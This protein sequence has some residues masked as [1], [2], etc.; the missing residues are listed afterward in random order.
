MAVFSYSALKS[1]GTMATGE[2]NAADRADAFRRLGRSGLQPVSLEAKLAGGG[3]T[4]VAAPPKKPA[5]APKPTRADQPAQKPAPAKASA[6]AKA[7]ARSPTKT[8][9]KLASGPVRLKRAHVVLFT[10]ELS[11]LLG[12][13]LQLEPALRI[14]E[15]RDELSNLKIVTGMIRQ[16]VRD[17]G[18][19]SNALRTSSPSFGELY[20][21]LAAAGEVSGALATI[22]KRQ[23]IYLVKLQELQNKVVV[24]M[25]Y[26]FCLLIAVVAVSFLFVSFL[27]P[28]L[29]S[30][31]AETGRELP[32][33]AKF[34]LAVSDFLGAYWWALILLLVAAVLIFRKVITIPPYEEKWHRV[35]LHLPLLGGVTSRR[36]FVQVV[37]T[38]SNLVGNGLPLLKGL[39]LTRNATINLYGRGL[40]D[41]VIV[42]V[43]EG[44]ALSRAMRK[45]GFFPPL[46][47][48]M[49]AVGEQTGNLPVALTRAAQRYDKELEKQIQRVTAMMQPVILIILAA[50]VGPMA[51]MMIRVILESVTGIRAGE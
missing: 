20:C 40:L 14:M 17:G 1:D 31:L 10:E 4:A 30:M 21:S 32:A 49:I 47:T 26:P 33:A 29:T 39:E 23:A 34:M 24:A 19:F 15:N 3:G 35:V 6:S 37:E 5:K 36:L 43:G 41:Q 12:A 2:V 9:E 38:L 16:Q 51:Y 8:T 13:G 11:D 22:L 18:S 25:I 42:M 44:G 50:I 46:L 7:P 28:Q 45:V 48:D 27:L